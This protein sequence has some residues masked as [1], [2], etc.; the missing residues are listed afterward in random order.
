MVFVCNHVI[1][2]GICKQVGREYSK[3][4]CEEP[5]EKTVHDFYP[6]D[7]KDPA[8]YGGTFIS[9]IDVRYSMN[10]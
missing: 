5:E 7:M 2:N 4:N 8:R 3:G 1:S 9:F 10:V 6:K